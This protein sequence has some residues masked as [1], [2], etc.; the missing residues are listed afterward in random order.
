MKPAHIVKTLTP[1][2]RN[3]LLTHSP[4]FGSELLVFVEHAGKLVA[5][6]QYPHQLEQLV[7][8]NSAV[9]VV[10]LEK[11]AG[12]LNQEKLKDALD[13]DLAEDLLPFL[14]CHWFVLLEALVLR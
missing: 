8:G 11:V 1:E 13:N 7:W 14:S 9:E 3:Q 4:Q 5:V 10:V 6:R 2:K 12:H